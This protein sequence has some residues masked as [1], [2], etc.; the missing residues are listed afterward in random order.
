M[1]WSTSSITRIVTS[2]NELKEQCTVHCNEL[3]RISK[4]KKF[5]LVNPIKPSEAN[6]V[7]AAVDSGF[8]SKQFL[9]L[10]VMLL[11]SVASIFTYNSNQLVASQYFPSRVPG[12]GVH[13]GVFTDTSDST[14]FKSLSRLAAE[15][16]CAVQT[17]K[18]YSPSILF[19]D[20]SLLPLPG[21]KPQQG[22]TL[23]SLYAEVLA[24][25]KEL[26][27]LASSSAN[28][29]E[30]VGIVKDSRS[31]KLCNLLERK[32][33]TKIAVNSDEFLSNLLLGAGE[34]TAV[35]SLEDSQLEFAKSAQCRG[36]VSESSP[37]GDAQNVHC[38]YMKSG[39]G[40]PYRVEFLSNEKDSEAVASTLAG[41]LYSLGSPQ[42]SYPSILIEVDMRAALTPAEINALFS[43][44]ENRTRDLV[45]RSNSRPFRQKM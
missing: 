22:S 2:M 36:I 4:E 19:I 9:S 1:H 28:G 30:L 13:Y 37:I 44:L 40:L 24:L 14:C 32:L 7:V 20:G 43:S 35:F 42:F 16:S 15:L 27:S 18:M 5:P 34:R 3:K 8:S 26:Y 12:I 29:C 23:E 21:D 45:L 25:Y 17:M 41:K 11:R 39:N 10:D 38:F 6:G 33:E 31:Q